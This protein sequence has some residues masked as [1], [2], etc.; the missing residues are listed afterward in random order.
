MSIN[1][2]DKKC[3]ANIGDRL[4]DV[5]R[6]NHSHIGYFCGGNA[7]CQTCYVKV[8]E[9]AEL[10]S[11]LSDPER[12]MLSDTLINEGT[13]MACMTTIDKPGT[14]T[15][16]TTVEEVKRMAQNNPLQLPAYA[17]KMGWAALEKFTD[18][19]D[20][21]ARR[22]QTERKLDP[23]ELLTDIF[24]A[25]TDAVQLTLEAVSSIFSPTVEK[26]GLTQP[27]LVAADET[28]KANTP[29]TGDANRNGKAGSPALQHVA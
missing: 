4:L 12:S 25:I 23:W 17:G 15:V 18:T 8:L 14:V 2:N 24:K 11:P 28:Q 10:L 5:A 1:I 27:H 3:E 13:R 20:F 16:L 7:I 21:Q 6:A 9:G 19:I 29:E 22:E 26:A